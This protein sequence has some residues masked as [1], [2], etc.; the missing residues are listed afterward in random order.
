MNQIEKLAEFF[1]QSLKSST[2][3]A[4][5]GY[6]PN[7]WGKQKYGNRIRKL[8]EDKQIDV[9]NREANYA[10]IRDFV[11]TYLDGIRLKKGNNSLECPT[12]STISSNE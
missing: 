12:C 8:Y 9:N 2:D 11:V 5:E 10:F 3:Q 4:P 6:C 1:K 7:C